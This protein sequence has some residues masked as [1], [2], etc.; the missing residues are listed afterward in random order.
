[1]GSLLA[2]EFSHAIPASKTWAFEY[3]LQEACVAANLL[4]IDDF[5]EDAKKFDI[6]FFKE[7]DD[8]IGERDK[9]KKLFEEAVAKV[10]KAHADSAPIAPLVPPARAVASRSTSMRIW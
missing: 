10:E 8:T 3:Y 7:L 4:A 9:Y 2:A 1:M 6:E 5:L